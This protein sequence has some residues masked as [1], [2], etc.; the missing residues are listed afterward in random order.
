MSFDD[1]ARRVIRRLLTLTV[2]FAATLG[3]AAN[4]EAGVSTINYDSFTAPGGYT[5]T[6]FNSKWSESFGPLELGAGH[7]GTQSFA[8]GQETVSAVPFD[9]GA[10]YGV[11]DHLKYIAISNQSFAMPTT[12]SVT[13]G[14]D[15]TARTSG[16]VSGLVQ[17]GV[18]GPSGTWTDPMSPPFT[19]NYSSPVREGQQAGVV[20]NMVDFC[21][22][23]LFDWFATS[24]TAFTLIERLPTVVTGNTS[25]PNCPDATNVGLDKMYTQIIRQIP[26]DGTTAHHYAITFARGGGSGNRHSVVLYTLDGHLI[27]AVPN[28]GVPLDQQGLIPWTGTYPSLGPGEDLTDQ[29]HSFSIGHGLFSLLDAFPF[30]HPAAPNLSVS[31]PVGTSNPAQAGRAR[32]FG[33]GAIGSWTN[34]NVITA[35]P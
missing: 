11:F 5:T 2:A 8:G 16:T 10:D 31:I 7:D 14:T 15:M 12:G 13:I 23:Q 34:F 6:N 9:I 17:Q 25:N 30:Q 33:Q 20:L 4:A 1:S 18:Y 28:V 27:S 26:L 29:I 24:H 35:T 21:T 32:L 3:I 19:P 22:G